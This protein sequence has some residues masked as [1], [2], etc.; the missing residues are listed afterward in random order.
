MLIKRKEYA[1]LVKHQLKKYME[2]DGMFKDEVNPN[3][4]HQ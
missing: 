4:K 3:K 2:Y 1:K